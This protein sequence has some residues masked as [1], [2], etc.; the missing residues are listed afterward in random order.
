MNKI[1]QPCSACFSLITRQQL[2]TKKLWVK[3]SVGNDCSSFIFAPQLMN[4]SINLN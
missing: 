3:L 1:S 2:N 4:R